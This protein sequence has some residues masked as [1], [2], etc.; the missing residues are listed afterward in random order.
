ML[1]HLFGSLISYMLNIRLSID[2]CENQKMKLG[3]PE[4]YPIKK[5]IGFD[6]EMLGAVDN[7]RRKQKP[8]PNVSEAIRRLVDLGLKGKR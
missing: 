1:E 3:R 6:E 8:I 4:V 7:W 2:I 5:V